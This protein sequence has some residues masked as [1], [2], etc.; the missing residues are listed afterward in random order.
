MQR[1]PLTY[2]PIWLFSLSYLKDDLNAHLTIFMWF[3]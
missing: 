3:S 2:K 1:I